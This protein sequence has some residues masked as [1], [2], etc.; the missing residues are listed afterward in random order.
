MTIMGLC[1][2]LDISHDTW[3]AYK[4]KNDFSGVTTRVEAIIWVQKF[5]GAA[6]DLLNPNI[7]ARDLGLQDKQSKEI[8][9]PDGGPIK[10]TGGPENPKTIGEWEDQVREADKN[11]AT[12]EEKQ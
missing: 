7:I 6:A 5:T 9:G 4:A 1:I 10:W 8:S 11:I 2:C 12:S 3:L